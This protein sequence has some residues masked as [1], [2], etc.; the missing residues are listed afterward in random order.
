VFATRTVPRGGEV[1]KK[2]LETHARVVEHLGLVRGV[3]HTEYILSSE[4]GEAYFLE[5]AARVGGVHIADLV[6]ASTGVNLWREWAKIEMSQ[7][8]IAYAV[9]P[10]G[11]KYAGLIVSLAKQEKPDLSAYTDPEIVWRM[12][13]NP[14]HAGLVVASDS[15][16]RI[17]ALLDD[18]EQRFAR[19]FLAVL[20]PPAQATA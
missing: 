2:L 6:V 14:N 3:T 13:D 17:E 4:D 19:D 16:E 20:P 11:R 12:T 10:S 7:G 18:Y 8:E 15:A 9:P 1:E 5:T